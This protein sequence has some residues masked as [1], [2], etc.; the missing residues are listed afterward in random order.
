MSKSLSLY[1]MLHRDHYF[2]IV[3]RTVIYLLVRLVGFKRI[4][5][6]SITTGVG[7]EI[8]RNIFF[9]QATID[10]VTPICGLMGYMLG[11]YKAKSET[12][13]KYFVREKTHMLL[14]MLVMF[15]LY[16]QLG[17]L[18]RNICKISMASSFVLGFIFYFCDPDEKYE[19]IAKLAIIV[20]IAI[21]GGASM[22]L[23]FKTQPK[24]I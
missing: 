1:G 2:W 5:L 13:W 23:F 22:W 4:L 8:I 14:I 7:G 16:L 24:L 15:L 20:L 9:G 19:K 12:K 17:F 6:M 10:S 18:Y 3:C 11:Y 21:V